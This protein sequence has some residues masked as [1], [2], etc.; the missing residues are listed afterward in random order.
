MVPLFYLFIHQPFNILTT[1]NKEL[2]RKTTAKTTKKT[3]YLSI[4]YIVIRMEFTHKR[5]QQESK[6]INMKVRRTTFVL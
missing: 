4:V 5:T 1:K 6:G 3:R 2:N